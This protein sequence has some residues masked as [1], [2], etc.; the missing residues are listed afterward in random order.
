[1]PAGRVSDAIV[2]TLDLFTSIA[3]FAGAALPE[4]KIDGLDLTPLLRGVEGAEG[5]DT[6]FFYSGDELHAVHQGRWKLHLPHEYLTVSARL[7]GPR[8]RRRQS[9]QPPHAKP[10]RAMAYVDGSGTATTPMLR[11]LLVAA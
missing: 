2:S 10:A 1:V 4:R 9:P 8:F 5:R 3:K 6:F 7:L 11:P